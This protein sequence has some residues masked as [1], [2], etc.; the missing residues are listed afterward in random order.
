MVGADLD[1]RARRGRVLLGTVLFVLGFT[2]V[3]VSFGLAFGG[4][5]R[6]AA[7]RTQ[8]LIT[9]VLGVL[10]IV[11][12]LA[13][14]GC[15]VPVAAARRARPPLADDSG[16]PGRRCSACCSGSAGRRASARPW[17]PC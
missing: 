6:A 12:G 1:G 7:R 13:F 10:T 16:W 17:A 11:L 8:R 9:R 2:V 4:A 3:F 14:M 15:C 5:R